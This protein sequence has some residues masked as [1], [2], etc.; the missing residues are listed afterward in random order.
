[1][2]LLDQDVEKIPQS[3]EGP[4]ISLS[5]RCYQMRIGPGEHTD[6]PDIADAL[7]GLLEIPSGGWTA[8]NDRVRK[9]AALS[10]F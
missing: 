1:M 10:S 5:T 6:G 8:M 2:G 3:G 9:N 4:F 7:S